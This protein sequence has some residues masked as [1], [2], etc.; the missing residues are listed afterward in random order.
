[1]ELSTLVCC[2]KRALLQCKCSAWIHAEN[3]GS[4]SSSWRFHQIIRV[5]GKWWKVFEKQNQI[6]KYCK[7]RTCKRVAEL[8]TVP[9]AT[10][11]LKPSS[12]ISFIKHCENCNHTG[13]YCQLQRRRPVVLLN[14]QNQIGTG[15][16]HPNL[17]S[18]G[19]DALLLSRSVFWM[20]FLKIIVG[21]VTRVFSV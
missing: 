15:T 10:F 1:M 5:E 18:A 11:S 9:V 20:V 7:Y 17:H 14:N 6:K 21:W 4:W 8:G 19:V 12:S 3:L 13:E 16:T 2:C